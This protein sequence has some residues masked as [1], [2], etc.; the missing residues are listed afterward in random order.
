MPACGVNFQHPKQESLDVAREDTLQLA[1]KSSE[2]LKM[3]LG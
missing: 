1:Y 3:G 2:R